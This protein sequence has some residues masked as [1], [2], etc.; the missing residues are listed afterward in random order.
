LALPA[1]THSIPLLKI[2]SRAQADSFLREA[3]ALNP[4]PWVRHS[5]FAA[6]AARSIARHHPRLDPETA[7]LLGY[8]HDIGRRAGKT[9]MR[10]TLDGYRFLERGGFE[11]AARICIS[12]TFPIKDLRVCAGE[13]DCNEAELEFITSFL[14]RNEWNEYDRLIQ[15]CDAVALPAG[16]CSVEERQRDI[17]ARY[18]MNGFSLARREAFLGILREME[19][20]IGQ[21]VY[22]VLAAEPGGPFAS[23]GGKILP[24]APG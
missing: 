13:W 5:W 23:H 21:P 4:G 15:L 9:G 16:F 20:A 10:H 2:P 22:G 12:H 3:E 18:G 11:D 17:D 24:P 8:L 19:A 6:C 14:K 7:F 1:Q